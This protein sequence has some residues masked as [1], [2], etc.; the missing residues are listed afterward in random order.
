M[1]ENRYLEEKYYTVEGKSAEGENRNDI[2]IFN[3]FHT[4]V[5]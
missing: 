2:L 4:V 3:T 5:L 1:P